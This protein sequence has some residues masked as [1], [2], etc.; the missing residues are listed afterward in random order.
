MQNVFK[1]ENSNNQLLLSEVEDKERNEI[2]NS[3][4]QICNVG[5]IF[6]RSLFGVCIPLNMKIKDLMKENFTLDMNVKVMEN[7]RFVPNISKTYKYKWD[8]DF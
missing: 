6:S 1:L 3:N 2:F 8:L 5:N 7:M 4:L